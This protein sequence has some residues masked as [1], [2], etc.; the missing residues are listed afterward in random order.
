MLDSLPTA[1]QLT[2]VVEVDVTSVARLRVREKAEFQRR[3]G[4]KLS[5]LLFF[6]AAAVETSG[7]P[8]GYQRVARR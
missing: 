8:P 3:H 2:T 1:A 7:R 5:F 4:A 6:V